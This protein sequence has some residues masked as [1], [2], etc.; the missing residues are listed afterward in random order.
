MPVG[1]VTLAG[2]G[3]VHA[4]RADE[5]EHEQRDRMPV[6][7]WLQFAFADVI[8]DVEHEDPAWLQHAAAF[9]PDRD[10]ES[11]VLVADDAIAPLQRA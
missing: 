6:G 5:P 1:A 2:A 3:H 8:L 7:D 4:P 10:V 9:G 11:T